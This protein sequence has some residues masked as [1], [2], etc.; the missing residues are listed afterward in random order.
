M[1]LA[2]PA[3]AALAVLAPAA[4]QSEVLSASDTHFVISLEAGSA[5]SVEALWQRLIHPDSWWSG[6]HSYSGDAAN[7]TLEPRA[8]G[9]WREEWPGGSVAHGR[10]LLAQPNKLLRLEAPFGP[11]QG[12]GAY[13]VWTITLEDDEGGSRVHFREVASAPPGS[14]MSTI[15]KAVNTV[16]TEAIERLA[17]P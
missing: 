16:K 15:A 3:L 14:D 2:Q 11:L 13:T 1:K 9:L 10:V 6:E 17:N 5:L 12:M 4:V 8:G 7:F